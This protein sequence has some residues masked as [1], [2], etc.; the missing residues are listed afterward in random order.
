MSFRNV[1]QDARRAEAYARIEFPATYYLAY[2]DL[3]ALLREHVR[4][5]RALDFGCGA[6]RSTRFLRGLGYDATGVDVSAEMIR[7]A[8]ARDPQGRYLL[9]DDAGLAALEPASYDLVTAIFPFDNIAGDELRLRL[10]DQLA[11]LLD[12]GG[13]LLLLASAPEL[14]LHEWVS[15]TTR[16]FPENRSARSGDHVRIVIRE[17][18][19][20]RPVDDL[21]WFDEDYR[22]LFERARLRVLATQQPL[23]RD[24]EP[25]A[26]V[27]ETR[28]SPWLIYVCAR[29]A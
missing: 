9:L 19:D 12:R 4:G 10:M 25:Y 17:A 29:S 8:R 5:S 13:V 28:V 23:G 2:R 11:G 26:W 22:A 27:S 18:D 20:A 16:D 3:P 6:G 7:H 24:D 21:I 1:Y 15:F 14:Y